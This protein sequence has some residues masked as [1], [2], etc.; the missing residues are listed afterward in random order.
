MMKA[1]YVDLVRAGKIAL[2][3]GPFPSEEVARK[4]ERA[5]VNKALEVDPW[6]SF[7]PYGVVSLDADIRPAGRINHLIEIDPAD[8]L[9]IIEKPRKEAA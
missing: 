2:L 4:Y 8:L 7:D 1:F 6:A 9:P 5:A 3:A